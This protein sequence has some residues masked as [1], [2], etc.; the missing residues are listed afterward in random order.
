MYMNSLKK[1]I[2]LCCSFFVLVQL[3]MGQERKNVIKTNP[4]FDLYGAFNLSYERALSEKW[5]VQ[6]GG[7]Y[8]RSLHRIEDTYVSPVPMT[9]NNGQLL[10]SFY[11]ENGKLDYTSINFYTSVRRYLKPFRG[12]FF[13][14]ILL[15]RHGKRIHQYDAK[16]EMAESW[17]A[18]L[19][20]GAGYRFLCW[21]RLSIDLALGGTVLKKWL[22]I[23]SG[24]TTEYSEKIEL[25]LLPDLSVGFIF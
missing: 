8:S 4:I 18:G 2:I 3:G 7:G 5:S 23:D 11:V 17:R 10:Q 22:R 13:E 16:V 12:V 24:A 20:V 1:V 21:K 25:G 6:V 15:G 14:G 19:G 9:G